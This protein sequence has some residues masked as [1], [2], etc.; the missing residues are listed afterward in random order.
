MYEFVSAVFIIYAYLGLLG[1]L[2]YDLP[3]PLIKS[4]F[5][6]IAVSTKA[7]TMIKQVEVKVEDIIKELEQ[8]AK[9]KNPVERA[10]VRLPLAHFRDLLAQGITHVSVPDLEEST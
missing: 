9:S 5:I 1:I 6:A 10:F 2:G 3:W 8:M 4:V 7:I